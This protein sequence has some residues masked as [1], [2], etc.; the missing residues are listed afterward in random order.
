MKGSRAATAGLV[1]ATLLLAVTLTM[2]ILAS[3]VWQQG[4]P[5]DYDSPATVTVEARAIGRRGSHVVAAFA[6][7]MLLA[8]VILG[9]IGYRTWGGFG[10]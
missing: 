1:L 2:A 6:W 10:W 9:F 5:Q 7:F 4:L 3:I 8:S